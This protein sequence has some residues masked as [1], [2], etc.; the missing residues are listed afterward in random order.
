M[1]YMILVKASQHSEKKTMPSLNLMKQ[2]DDYND[3]IEQAGVKVMAKG[4]LPTESAY[5]IQFDDASRPSPLMKGPFTP[6][7]EQVSGFFLIEVPSEED[8]L[9]WFSKVPD[10]IGDGQGLIELRK[11]Y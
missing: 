9:A 11:V 1:L 6:S 10:P 5:R 2:M 3:A 8:A 7:S 4:L